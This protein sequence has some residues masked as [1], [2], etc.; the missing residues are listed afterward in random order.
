MKATGE[1][2][3]VELISAKEIIGTELSLS[4]Y[5]VNN[6]FYGYVRSIGPLVPEN[7]GVDVGDKVLMTYADPFKDNFATVKPSQIHVVLKE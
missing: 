3:L 7:F 1:W 6:C 5:E 2:I 4:G